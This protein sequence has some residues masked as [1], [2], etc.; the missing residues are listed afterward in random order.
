[1]NFRILTTLEKEQGNG[2]GKLI[3]KAFCKEFAERENIDLISF[4][5]DNNYPS[6]NIF[7]KLNFQTIGGGTW[8]KI[9]RNL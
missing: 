8:L 1:M 9:K 3:T 6:L 4:V 5:V 7:K 2:Y